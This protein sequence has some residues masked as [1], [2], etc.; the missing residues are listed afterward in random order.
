MKKKKQRISAEEQTLLLEIQIA[1]RSI[2]TALSNLENLT[3]PDLIDC[4]IY[5]L[6]AA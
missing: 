3:D 2:L 5:E 4:S 1:K 6:N